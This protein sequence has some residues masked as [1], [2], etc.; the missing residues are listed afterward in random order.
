E[1]HRAARGEEAAATEQQHRR[2]DDRY[3]VEEGEGRVQAA[4]EVDQQRLYDEISGDLHRQ[5]D[6]AG[7]NK[8]RDD[9]VEEGEAVRDRRNRVEIVDGQDF[10]DGVLND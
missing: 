5:I 1:H 3:Q 6:L 4:G 8:L 2:R 7:A 9:D 10:F